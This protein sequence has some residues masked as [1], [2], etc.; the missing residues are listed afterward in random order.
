MLTIETQKYKFTPCIMRS[1]RPTH[2]HR[3]TH[4]SKH[5]PLHADRLA[6][7]NHATDTMIYTTSQQTT[8]RLFEQEYF[9][10]TYTTFSL[11]KFNFIFFSFLLSFPKN[12][13][14]IITIQISL[15]REYRLS[16]V[17]MCCCE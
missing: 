17:Y 15:L 1:N 13:T 9:L 12:R 7:I 11:Y 16:N 3:F 4:S 6:I 5:C 10:L 8:I 14:Y 2:E